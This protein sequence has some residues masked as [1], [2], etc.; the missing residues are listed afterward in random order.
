[1]K[2]CT[3]CGNQMEDDML[4]C[5]KCG[6][7][8]MGTNISQE[9][10]QDDYEDYWG[11]SYFDV[12]S[13]KTVELTPKGVHIFKKAPMKSFCIDKTIPYSDIIEISSERATA[14]SNGYF[15]VVTAT[16]GITRKIGRFEMLKDENTLLF[17]RKTE[18]VAERIYRAIEDV[19]KKP[20]SS[21]VQ[22]TYY[23]MNKKPTTYSSS[24]SNPLKPQ[25]TAL[26]G[27]VV[28]IVIILLFA[29]IGIG[30]SQKDNESSPSSAP[31][32]TETTK[33]E[34]STRIRWDDFVS[35]YNTFAEKDSA[36]NGY[37][38]NVHT[39]SNNFI[40][41]FPNGETL[42]VEL[43]SNENII[44]ME[45]QYPSQGTNDQTLIMHRW[46]VITSIVCAIQYDLNNGEMTSEVE[47][48]VKKT[49][50]DLAVADGSEESKATYQSGKALSSSDLQNEIIYTRYVDIDKNISHFIVYGYGN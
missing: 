42:N 46:W 35:A 7:K 31:A 13:S 17:T 23:E 12:E 18:P 9:S 44:R 1:M 22:Y 39:P 25:N 20:P 43:T 40:Y 36:G 45:Y 3:K 15:S 30:L 4:F 28:P 2:Y 48:N 49:V 26:I 33:I 47:S 32:I 34:E 21:Q 38:I 27:W 41:E 14:L 37:T 6:M 10:T 19:C 16:E 11:L 5:Q 8:C 29:I 50:S 24:L